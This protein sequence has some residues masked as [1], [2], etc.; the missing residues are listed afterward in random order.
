MVPS[1]FCNLLGSWRG[2]TA[3][4]NSTQHTDYSRVHRLLTIGRRHRAVARAAGHLVAG[5][6]NVSL[7][8]SPRHDCSGTMYRFIAH[9]HCDAAADCSANLRAD[10]RSAAARE[11]QPRRR[12]VADVAC[13]SA[14]AFKVPSRWHRSPSGGNKTR[15]PRKKRCE[16]AV[17]TRARK[18]S[19]P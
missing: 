7:R 5:E 18:H 14:V 12:P 2:D 3:A 4:G 8:D 9:S 10:Y 19:L 6:G 11:A 16:A 13:C 15:E 17:M 1:H